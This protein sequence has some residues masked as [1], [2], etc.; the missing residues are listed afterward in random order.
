M[1]GRQR[2]SSPAKLAVEGS[3]PRDDDGLALATVVGAAFVLSILV[4]AMVQAV[5]GQQGLARSDQDWQASLAAAEAGIDDYLF[6]LNENPNYYLGAPSDGNE[7]FDKLVPVPG[8]PSDAEFTYEVDTSEVAVTGA[9]KITAS[10]KVRGRHRTI[11]SVLRKRGF[12]DYLYFTNFETMDP[13]RYDG[14]PFTPS[15]AQ[16]HCAKWY[17][18]GRHPSCTNIWFYSGDTINGPLHSNDAIRISGTPTFNDDVSTSYDNSSGP[19]YVPYGGNFGDNNPS[20][21]TSGDPHV[22]Q[23]LTM[24]P[25]NAGIKA[26][27]DWRIDGTGCL[28]TGPTRI[29]FVDDAKL[30]V[31]SPFTRD[32]GPHCDFTPVL[33]TEA[34]GVNF[35]IAYPENGVIYVQNVPADPADPN[36]NNGCRWP[37]GG[38]VRGNHPFRRTNRTYDGSLVE[39]RFQYFR[40]WSDITRP[41]CTDG[42]AFVQGPANG[43]AVIDGQV[44]IAAENDIVITGDL[45]YKDDTAGTD[46]LGLVA[47]NSVE[48]YHPVN[49]GGN[50]VTLPNSFIN[51]LLDNITIQA[52]ILSLQHSFTVQNYQYGNPLGDLTVEGAIAQQYRGP[53]GTFNGWT[54]QQV[55]GYDKV[56]IYDNRLKYL[57]PPYFLDPVESAWQQ[58]TW[59]ENKPADLPGGG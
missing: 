19:N 4:L 22:Q 38:Q 31:S 57:S 43:S 12:L 51:G 3:S 42:D 56:Y 27:T 13:A 10:G 14:N 39:M 59:E 1:T 5:I 33:T 24:P 37:N 16:Q 46:V 36:Y 23:V 2:N 20:F 44:T 9:L 49:S 52:A 7:A 28:F 6:R 32:V 50:N 58:S 18:A 30:W 41:G 55:S 21:A 35:G 8:A 48:V 11:T 54:G 53:V 40:R 29:M 34:N 26:R 15:Q 25:S 45:R 47:N 17:Y